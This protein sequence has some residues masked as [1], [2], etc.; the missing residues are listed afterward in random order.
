VSGDDPIRFG[1]VDSFNRP[2]GN[3]T[4]VSFLLTALEAKRLELMAFWPSFQAW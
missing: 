2:G 3:V 4:G 1:L